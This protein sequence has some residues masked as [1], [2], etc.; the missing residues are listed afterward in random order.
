MTEDKDIIK[1]FELLDTILS[2]LIHDCDAYNGTFKSLYLKVTDRE[3]TDDKKAH[4]IGYLESI[5]KTE[6][7]SI[8]TF[9]GLGFSDNTLAQGEKIVEACYYL[10]Q[11]N[12][13]R[14][15][16]DF[17]LKITYEGIIKYSKGFKKEF[18]FENH[19]SILDVYNVYISIGLTL[20]GLI[21]GY[22]L[23]K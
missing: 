8:N 9:F 20:V 3:L 7:F 2:F 11:N 23:G 1:N 22:F 4:S 13:V 10:M 21:V 15:S 19:K 14:I 12:Y 16:S 17:D 6:E 5:V 18:K